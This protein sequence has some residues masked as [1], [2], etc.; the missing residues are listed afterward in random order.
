M[1]DIDTVERAQR[2]L[3]E[4][5]FWAKVNKSGPI[6][7][8]VPHLGE[9]WEWTAYRMANGGYGQIRLPKKN[10]SAHR[11]SWLLT[12]GAIPE[13]MQVCHK[14][15][16]P[17][18]VRPDHLFVGTAQDN[19]RDMIAKGRKGHKSTPA[20]TNVYTSPPSMLVSGLAIHDNS[21]HHFW[22]QSGNQYVLVG[23]FDTAAPNEVKSTT[24]P[25]LTLDVSEFYTLGD[26]FLHRE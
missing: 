19:M 24:P 14:C 18:C 10:L 26:L 12:Y 20:A 21:P 7:A 2:I 23:T 8:H 5:R 11:A 25:T 4:R 15:D 9:C 16:N 1:N 6:P 22:G 13:G 17:P 3:L